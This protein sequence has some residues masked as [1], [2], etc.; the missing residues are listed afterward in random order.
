M[1]VFHGMRLL[2]SGGLEA[3]IGED[4]WMVVRSIS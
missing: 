3:V 4:R 1:N 2:R